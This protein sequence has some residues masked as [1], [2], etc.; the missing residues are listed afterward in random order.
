V[1]G[2]LLEVAD[3]PGRFVP[4]SNIAENCLIAAIASK[5]TVLM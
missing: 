5:D 3:G 4:F 1:G 2:A